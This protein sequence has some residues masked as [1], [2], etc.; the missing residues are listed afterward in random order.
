MAEVPAGHPE[1]PQGEDGFKL[2]ERMNGGHHEELANW[3]LSFLPVDADARALDIGCG[4][5][6]NIA[7]LLALAP[8]GHVT[9]VD[10][11]PVSVQASSNHNA[12]AIAGGR[13]EVLEADSAA[14]PFGDS[15]FDVVTA[16]ETVYYWDIAAAFAEVARVLVPGGCFLVC[17][18]DDGCDP[19][20]LKLAEQI[21]GMVMHTPVILET[22]LAQSGLVVEQVE[23]IPEK[24]HLAIIARNDTL[25]QR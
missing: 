18:E 9:G 23:R 15:S 5:G 13:C 8:S 25:P 19:E 14:L 1:K 4:G 16:F 21:P 2:L 24:G 20:A 7:R 11:S 10:Y 17:N 3:G 12:D 22:A 6:A